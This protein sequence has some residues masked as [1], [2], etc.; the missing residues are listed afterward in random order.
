MKSPNIVLI[1][2]DDQGY[3]SLGSY[4]NKEVIS[5]NLDRLA[6][7]GMKFDNFYCTSPV[8]SPARAS[9]LT[10][11][12]PS[13][14]G[15]LDW[16]GGG[17]LCKEDMKDVPINYRKAIPALAV[18][19]DNP[20]DI[21]EDATITYEN[22][23]SYQKYMTF[24]TGE[25]DFLKDHT[26]FAEI[27]NNNGYRC[28]MSGK[29]H[30][31]TARL[32]HKGFEFW[33]P[34]IKGGCNYDMGDFFK[35]GKPVIK[36]GYVTDLITDEAIRFIDDNNEDAP[37]FLSV[38]YNAPHDPW[39]SDQHPKELLDLYKDCPF[40]SYPNE[41]KHPDQVEKRTMP[42]TPEKLKEFRQVYYT[43]VT[44]M[45]KGVGQIVEKLESKGMLENTV[46]MFTSD[47]GMNMGHHGIWGKGNGTFPVNMFETSVKVPFIAYG[48]GV[49]G[50][51]GDCNTLLSHYDLF[52]TILD[53]ANIPSG[54]IDNYTKDIPGSSMR[55]VLDGSQD[56]VRP[57]VVVY[58]EYGPTR[59]VRT[60]TH[61]LIYRSPFGPHELY[62]ISPDHA[63][64]VNEIENP[65]YSDIKR[66]LYTK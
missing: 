10:G 20:N 18:K 19:P 1:L 9:I 23:M 59:M 55:S 57:E 7:E 35:D 3:W 6:S 56:S 34:I 45:D 26:T 15:V 50:K 5:P 41:E 13:A 17:A 31:G 58:D 46:I 66:E 62:D 51:V 48:K 28:G 29:W 11:K 27:L 2:T 14:H 16:L 49:N 25:I 24:E 39:I 37:F 53:I 47:N 33:E 54:E 43:C 40:E 12:I 22:T 8:C 21:P 52:P 32:P 60:Q 38:N 63:E 36:D 61:K 4:G 42:R 30:L 44:A 65:A 64:L